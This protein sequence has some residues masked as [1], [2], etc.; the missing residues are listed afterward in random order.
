MIC[1]RKISLSYGSCQRILWKDMSIRK[2]S[3]KFVPRLLK[4]EQNENPLS[5]SREF[6]YDP[7][8]LSEIIKERKRKEGK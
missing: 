8:F 1:E 7:H 3:A 2:I 6:H 5:V 4:D